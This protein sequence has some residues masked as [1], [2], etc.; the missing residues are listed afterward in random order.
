M[1]KRVLRRIVYFGIPVAM[2]IAGAACED[3]AQQHQNVVHTAAYRCSRVGCDKRG[4]MAM[5]GVAPVCSCGANMVVDYT[6]DDRPRLRT[7]K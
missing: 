5:G 4:Q 7:G 2:W 3:G 1:L 6:D